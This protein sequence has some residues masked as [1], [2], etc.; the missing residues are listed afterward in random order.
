MTFAVGEMIVRANLDGSYVRMKDVARL[1]LGTEN[2]N[3][4][5]R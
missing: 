1:E 5:G 4:I 2:Y 3:Q